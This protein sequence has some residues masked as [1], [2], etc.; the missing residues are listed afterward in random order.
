MANRQRD[1][2]KEQHL[3]QLFCDSENFL[4][5]SPLASVLVVSFSPILLEPGLR[6][7]IIVT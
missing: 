4:S 2:A 1:P 5:L 6:V 7:A 3:P